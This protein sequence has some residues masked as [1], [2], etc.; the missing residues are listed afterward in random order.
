M[1]ISLENKI[2]LLE[3]LKWRPLCFSKYYTQKLYQAKEAWH[4]TNA[5]HDKLKTESYSWAQF[6]ACGSKQINLS[7]VDLSSHLS[8]RQKTPTSKSSNDNFML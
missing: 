6:L 4:N 5:L 3:T 8:A 7:K 1:W 2:F